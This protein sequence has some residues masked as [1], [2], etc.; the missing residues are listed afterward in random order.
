M[1]AKCNFDSSSLFYEYLEYRVQKC[2]IG[3]EKILGKWMKLSSGQSNPIEK[4][5]SSYNIGWFQ[6]HILVPL[7]NEL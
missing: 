6:L 1:R 4:T 5:I 3:M 7:A 2:A